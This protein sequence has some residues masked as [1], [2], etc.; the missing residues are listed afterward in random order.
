MIW[1]CKD[2]TERHVGCHGKCERY[3]KQNEEHQ[4]RLAEEKKANDVQRYKN[5][6]SRKWVDDRAKSK[7]NHS[8]KNYRY[9]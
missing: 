9:R 7:K 2:C 4:K 3:I 8:G 1:C 6:N 5:E